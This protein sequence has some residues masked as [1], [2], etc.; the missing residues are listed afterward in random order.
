MSK[1]LIRE[2]SDDISD[3]LCD[4]LILFKMTFSAT[5]SAVGLK[6]VKDLAEYMLITPSQSSSSFL[7]I[8]TAVACVLYLTLPVTVASAE[9]SFS[10][11]KLIKAFLTSTISQVRLSSL[12]ILSMRANAWMTWT[13]TTLSI[14]LMI[15]KL[16]RKSF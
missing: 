2:Y 7:D 6:S 3:E 10:E 1:G 5:L 11:L 15:T 8:I 12:A 4:H 14:L 16:A 13:L 9:R